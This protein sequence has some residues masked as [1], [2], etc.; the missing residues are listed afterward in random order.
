M[1]FT[2]FSFTR[3][4][5]FFSFTSPSFILTDIDLIKR[6]TI[7]DYDFFLNHQT[8]SGADEIFDRTLFSLQDKKWRDMR[9]TLSPIFTS[10]KMKSMFGLLTAH[11]GDFIK[12]YEGKAKRGEEIIVDALDLFLKFTSDGIST[13]VMGFEADCVTNEDSYIYG[14]VKS[15]T[16]DFLGGAASLK[17][18][19]ATMF[20]KLYKLTGLQLIGPENREFFRKAVID[21]MDE[22]D[23]NNTSRPDVIQ[24]LLQA[25][26]GQLQNNAKENDVNEK[27]LANFSANVEYDVSGSDSKA[28]FNDFDWI[29]QGLIFFGAGLET[30]A[31]LLQVVCYELARNEN[32]QRKLQDEIDSVAAKLN[33]QPIDYETLHKMKFVDMIISE[34]LRKWPPVP[35]TD[36]VCSKDYNVDLGNG[37]FFTIRKGQSILLPTFLI[38]RDAD[39]FPN[40]DKFDPYRFSDENKHLIAPGSYLPFGSGPRTCIGSRFA[41]ME[42]KLMVF[43][44]FGKFSVEKC[45]KTP[46]DLTFQPNVANRIKEKIFLKFKLRE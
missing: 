13:T 2:T 41:L 34:T 24:L 29:A 6:L 38:H 5:G 46:V 25:K 31:S 14:R 18:V 20:P 32:I 44:F 3:V 30:T 7:K 1:N 33:G 39:H 23:R 40:P 35:H 11:V 15:L 16:N 36:R 21:T 27:E 19:L 8:S 12:F 26:K 4:F 42:A 45:D 37:R 9:S 43:N 17:F 28:Q 22:R 10:S